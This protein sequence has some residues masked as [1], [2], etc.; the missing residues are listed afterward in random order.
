MKKSPKSA[1]TKLATKFGYTTYVDGNKVSLQDDRTTITINFEISESHPAS[2]FVYFYVRTTSW[3]LDGERTDAN[4]FISTMLAV[5]LRVEA[6]VSA[7]L[8]DI[9]HP[10][11]PAAEVEVYARYLVADQPHGSD[12]RLD[13]SE[14]GSI[15]L[16]LSTVRQF[17]RNMPE[18][19][20][21]TVEDVGGR[22][23]AESAY[24]WKD[25]EDWARQVAMIVSEFRGTEDLIELDYPAA[26]ML[27]FNW[28][29]NPNW[30]YYRNIN[31]GVSLYEMPGFASA[32]ISRLQ[33]SSPWQ[34]LEGLGCKLYLS[35]LTCNVVP[36]KD[37]RSVMEIL[38]KLCDGGKDTEIACVP[39]E[40][41]VVFAT[42][43]HILFLR[44]DAG[45]K[46]FEIEREEV[47]KRHQ[48]EARV[49]FPLAT[50]KWRDR[51]DDA[52]FESLVLALLNRERG[53]VRARLV[54]ASN[55]PDGGRDILCE[56]LTPPAPGSAMT[57]GVSPSKIRNV[58]VQCKAYNKAVNK[59]DVTDIR[60]T[61][62]HY[63]ADGY[64]LVVA[65][66]LTSP[67]TTHLDR[68]RQEGKLWVDWWTRNEIEERLR[69]N[70]GIA[71]KFQGVVECQ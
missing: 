63:G 34:V 11:V 38:T 64:F 8:W 57:D 36:D 17:E 65:S 71:A 60:D 24:G 46:R 28:R 54:S 9:P 5:F 59:S 45:R 69:L 31:S 47:R 61:V 21:W 7:S 58:I 30:K 49:L 16:L 39:L 67:L 52:E 25:L 55:D 13:P 20:D 40:K 48:E 27:Q 70:R 44:S 37:F 56:W 42:H 15:E 68:M 26:D 66:R 1:L 3:D 22:L 19:F 4:D 53:V 23:V 33:E 10:A 29:R 6:G 41:Q 32:I 2:A 18:C 51:I 43:T 35:D 12:Y 62:E 14:L 50:F